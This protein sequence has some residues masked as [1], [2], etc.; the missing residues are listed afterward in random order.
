M[1]RSQEVLTCPTNTWTELTNSD[2]ASVTFQVLDGAVEVHATVG[3][4]PPAATDR[5]FMYVNNGVGHREGEIDTLLTSYAPG[6]TRLYA[7]GISGRSAVV[8]VS[9]A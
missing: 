5:G 2:T 7:R 6:S 4:V 8:L 9:H 3:A 1:A